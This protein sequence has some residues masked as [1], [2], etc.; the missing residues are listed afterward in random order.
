M[1]SLPLSRDP[2][3][4]GQLGWR[5]ELPLG[6]DLTRFAEAL[7]NKGFQSRVCHPTLCLFR[8]AEGHELVFVP[9][10]GRVGIRLHHGTPE[11]HR[12]ALAEELCHLLEEV[13]ILLR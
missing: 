12:V 10:T 6:L 1:T 3:C 8:N 7:G 13:L 5:T 11:A 9:A 2:G 4:L